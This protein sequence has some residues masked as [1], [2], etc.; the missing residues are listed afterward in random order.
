[1]LVVKLENRGLIEIRC[2]HC[3]YNYGNSDEMKPLGDC[4]FAEITC[5]NCKKLFWWSRKVLIE[6]ITGI[7]EPE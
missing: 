7:E 4:D 6:Y 2:P 5:E 3:G 1:M